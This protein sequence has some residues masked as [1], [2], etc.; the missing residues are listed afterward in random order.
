MVKARLI[1]VR[2]GRESELHD[3]SSSEH[4]PRPN[5]QES[6][7]RLLYAL[8]HV[9]I[10][11]RLLRED[12]PIAQRPLDGSSM[13]VCEKVSHFYREQNDTRDS[14]EEVREA[15]GRPGMLCSGSPVVARI[16]ALAFAIVVFARLSSCLGD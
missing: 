12:S 3:R 15:L 16:C 4:E 9:V 2:K 5:A 8:L 6:P 7:Q 1:H 10:R 11:A 14:P 13:A